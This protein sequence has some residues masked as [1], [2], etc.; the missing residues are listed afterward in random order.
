MANCSVVVTN[1]L[2]KSALSTAAARAAGIV[3]ERLK[4]GR[5]VLAAVE[6][7]EASAPAP[8]AELL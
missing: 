4:T 3:V 2:A 1:Q 8:D 5:R 6:I 7:S